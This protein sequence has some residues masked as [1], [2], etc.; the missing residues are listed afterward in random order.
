MYLQLVPSVYVRS[1]FHQCTSPVFIL[2]FIQPLHLTSDSHWSHWELRNCWTQY[3]WFSVDNCSC[4]DSSKMPKNLFFKDLYC[5]F[6]QLYILSKCFFLFFFTVHLSSNRQEKKYFWDCRHRRL[7]FCINWNKPL[8]DWLL[9]VYR[10]PVLCNHII[11][12]WNIVLFISKG[13]NI[14]FGHFFSLYSIH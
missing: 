10:W 9:M 7:F 6:D 1:V 14:R 13:I 3:L 2:F 12:I 4:R 8:L 11:I 5:D